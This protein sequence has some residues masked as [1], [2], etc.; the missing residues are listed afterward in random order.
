[1]REQL[2]GHHHGSLAAVQTV[3]LAKITDKL[4]KKKFLITKRSK[5]LSR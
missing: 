1:M 2:V 3:L 4:Y 5:I